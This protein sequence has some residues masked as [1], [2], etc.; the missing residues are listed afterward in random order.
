MEDYN[1]WKDFFDTYQSFPDWMK[2]LWLVVPPAF[3][4]GLLALAMRYRVALKQADCGTGG[5][6]VYTIHRDDFDQLR[7]YRHN[8]ETGQN[9]PVL[10]LPPSDSAHRE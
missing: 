10:L 9:P 7:I 4:L 5:T 8:Q 3:A 1:F 6:L 2:A